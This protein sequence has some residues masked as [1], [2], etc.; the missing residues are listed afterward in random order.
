MQFPRRLQ[1][2][3]EVRLLLFIACY[4]ILKCYCGVGIEDIIDWCF[5]EHG[6]AQRMCTLNFMY[7]GFIPHWIKCFLFNAGSIWMKVKQGEKDKFL[8]LFLRLK[9][10]STKNFSSC[11]CLIN[12]KETTQK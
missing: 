3:P 1:V 4:Q 8:F 11:A 10:L 2:N 6:D 12:D 9:M 5:V 7:K